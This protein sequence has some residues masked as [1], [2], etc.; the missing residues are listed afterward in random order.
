MGKEKY[1]SKPTVLFLLY[2]IKWVFEFN[3]MRGSLFAELEKFQGR[4]VAF[5]NNDKAYNFVAQMY[6]NKDIGEN[7]DYI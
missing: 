7:S 2:N 3:K 5:N 4:T 6:G 1:N